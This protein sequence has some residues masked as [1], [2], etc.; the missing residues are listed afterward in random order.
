MLCLYAIITSS[1]PFTYL[2]VRNCSR[3][4]WNTQEMDRTQLLELY[5]PRM[6]PESES[7]L[8]RVKL[9]TYFIKNGSNNYETVY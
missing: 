1:H 7:L 4:R 2:F 3:R 8:N 5:P 9:L 6:Q